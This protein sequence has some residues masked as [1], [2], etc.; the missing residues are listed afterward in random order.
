MPLRARHGWAECGPKREQG[1]H[2]L[3]KKKKLFICLLR[4]SSVVPFGIL[5]AAHRLL[6]VAC[7]VVVWGSSLDAPA[8]DLNSLDQDSNPQPLQ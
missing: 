7:K 2:V 8:C 6:A 3:K 4:V 1:G 5:T